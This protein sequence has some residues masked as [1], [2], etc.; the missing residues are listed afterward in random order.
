MRKS[1]LIGAVCFV[2]VF[3]FGFF[4]GYSSQGKVRQEVK[5]TQ[6]LAQDCNNSVNNLQIILNKSVKLNNALLA[7]FT[8]FNSLDDTL[9]KKNREIHYLYVEFKEALEKK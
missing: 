5:K 4:V 8:K 7:Y 2:I 6:A 3:V 1:I 9:N